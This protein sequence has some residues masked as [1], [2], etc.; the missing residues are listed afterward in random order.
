[1][2]I[3]IKSELDLYDINSLINYMF[4]NEFDNHALKIIIKDVLKAEI[5]AGK[6]DGIQRRIRDKLVTNQSINDFFD[7]L[8]LPQY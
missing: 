2:K 1:M 8:L 7:C 6:S 3:K 4:A 5:K